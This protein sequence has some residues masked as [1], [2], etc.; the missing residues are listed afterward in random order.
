MGID[1][2]EAGKGHAISDR[3]LLWHRNL[4]TWNHSALPFI[5]FQYT[6]RGENQAGTT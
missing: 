3:L 4:G 5:S 6:V 2:E 1:S